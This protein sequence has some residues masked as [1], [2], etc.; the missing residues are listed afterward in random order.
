MPMGGGRRGEVVMVQ[1]SVKTSLK[2]T[3]KFQRVSQG[4]S[5]KKVFFV[6]LLLY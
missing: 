3:L 6:F 5:K 4:K 1:F 2:L